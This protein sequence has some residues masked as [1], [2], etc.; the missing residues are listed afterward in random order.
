MSRAGRR[1]I[2]K[3]KKGGRKGGREGEDQGMGKARGMAEVLT[4]WSSGI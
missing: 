2:G 3:G 4:N 1:E